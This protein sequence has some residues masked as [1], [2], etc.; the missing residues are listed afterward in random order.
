MRKWA[1]KKSVGAGVRSGE[2]VAVV[3]VVLQL[4]H[5]SK[6]AKAGHRRHGDT[7]TCFCAV[8]V[9]LSATPVAAR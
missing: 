7:L 6:S 9:R 2:Q 8:I 4:S 3:G 1:G 5:I